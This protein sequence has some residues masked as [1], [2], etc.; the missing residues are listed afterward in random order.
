MSAASKNNDLR[1]PNWKKILY[2]LF[3]TC[4]IFLLGTG[5]V[6]AYDMIMQSDNFSAQE[7]SISGQN[8][9]SQEEIFRIAGIQKNTNILNINIKLAMMKLEATPWIKKAEIKRELPNKLS[10]KITEEIPI[11]K[12]SLQGVS[13]KFLL[14]TDLKLFK[15]SEQNDPDS[16]IPEVLGLSYSDIKNKNF[17]LNS[18]VKVLNMEKKSNLFLSGKTSI[19]KV[20]RDTGILIS[21]TETCNSLVLGFNDF[22]EKYNNLEKIKIY[23]NKKFPGQK[24]DKIDLSQKN[25]VIIKPFPAMG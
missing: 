24:M 22:K 25:R 10:I 1:V 13:Q 23:L 21:N 7:I 8:K 9:V 20:D 15:K 4:F 6:F 5:F 19:I 18:V 14:N 16:D 3:H 2:F 11:A 17:Y 12:I